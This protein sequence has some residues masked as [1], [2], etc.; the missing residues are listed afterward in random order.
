MRDG[1]R[2]NHFDGFAYGLTPEQDRVEFL[3]HQRQ[4]RF[5]LPRPKREA[6]AVTERGYDRTEKQIQGAMEAEDRRQWRA[7]LLVV[8]AKLE[9]VESGI[10]VFEA[11]D[12]LARVCPAAP[13]LHERKR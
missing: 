12:K 8:R 10:A 3:W 9:A 2:Q 6:F 1:A 5:A 4:I 11:V 7:L 13:A